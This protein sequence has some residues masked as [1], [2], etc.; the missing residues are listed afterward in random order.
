MRRMDKL[1]VRLDRQ[2]A[3]LIVYALTKARDEAPNDRY[4]AL[5]GMLRSWLRAR[6]EK[7]WGDEYADSPIAELVKRNGH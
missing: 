1:E 3:D 5:F 2:Q 6:R 7:R 4:K